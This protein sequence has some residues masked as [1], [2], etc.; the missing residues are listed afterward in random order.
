MVISHEVFGKS[1]ILKKFLCEKEVLSIDRVMFPLFD[2]THEK[3][4]LTILVKWINSNTKTSLRIHVPV[5][6]LP[7]SYQL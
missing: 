2:F 3:Y 7:A 6:H 1:E 5:I 4:T